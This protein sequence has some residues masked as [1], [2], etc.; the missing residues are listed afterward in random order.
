MKAIPVARTPKKTDRI[1][2][3]MASLAAVMP[4]KQESCGKVKGFVGARSKGLFLNS[5]LG[6]PSFGLF[7]PHSFRCANKF[8]P[9]SWTTDR[10]DFL[11]GDGGERVDGRVQG[12]QSSGE[13]AGD[14]QT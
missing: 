4:L 1:L 2:V 9:T 14:E 8:L 11:P 3:A 6:F 7:L 13:E 10:L 5:Q 12:A